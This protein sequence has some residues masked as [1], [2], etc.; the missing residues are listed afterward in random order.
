[1]IKFSISFLLLI[2]PLAYQVANSILIGSDLDKIQMQYI[3]DVQ[4]GN[5]VEEGLRKVNDKFKRL[6]NLRSY[7]PWADQ[8]DPDYRHASSET[9]ENWKDM[10]F[11]IR[12]HWGIYCL[13]GSN[14]SWSLW[15][16]KSQIGDPTSSYPPRG[17]SNEQFLDYMKQYCT[18]YQDFNPVNY[19]AD[20]W[21]D[22][23]KR[24]GIKFAVITTKHHDGFCMFD[25]RTKVNALRRVEN[26]GKTEYENV[27]NHYSI[28]ETPYKRDIVANFTQAMRKKG[29]AVGYYFSNPDWMDY[30]A[31]FGQANI[32]R[33]TTYTRKADPEGWNRFLL[34][35]REQLRELCSNYGK[36]DI[37]SFDHGLPM[38]AWTD[39]KETLKMIRRLQPDIML[40][41][42][43]INAW[44]DYFTP[45]GW[46]P[47]DYYDSRINNQKPWSVIGS[48]G[49]HP[50][51][52]F[53]E[54]QKYP[55]VESLIHKLII[56]VSVGGT[57]QLGFGPG[58][59]GRFDAKAVRILELMGDWLRVNGEGI[60]ATRPRLVFKEGE[61]IRFTRSK[62]NKTAY[63]ICL[64]WPGKKLVLRSLQARQQ[65]EIFL[66][67]DDKPLRWK[68]EINGLFI[69]LP[70]RFQRK[71]NRPCRHAYVFKI[72]VRDPFL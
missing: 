59:D 61:N 25:T 39:F 24:A 70:I 4:K 71:E 54:D 32:F 31:R 12:I 47:D 5:V 45:E 53:Q 8:V 29:I 23:Y 34:R 44:G 43:G 18:F 69:E 17:F 2:T 72:P 58:P 11:G 14:P 1:M 20:E 26:A 33:D 28:M 46:H 62:D 40:R 52:S 56:I 42:R 9:V 30:D 65:G 68:Q 7:A 10:K 60:Y 67:G 6:Y 49:L 16:P 3:E 27:Y 50:G 48:T 19:N 41:H 15:Y 63:A 55:S 57:F 37:L 51:Y 36:I 38:D 21:A 13:N 66:L 64:E 22:L 35:H